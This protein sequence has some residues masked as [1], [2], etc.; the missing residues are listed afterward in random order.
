MRALG[1]D[2]RKTEV[3]KIMKDYDRYNGKV[4]TFPNLVSCRNETGQ[5]EYADFVDIMTQKVFC[6]CICLELPV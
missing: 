4:K 2:V 1:F 3:L 5:I 6:L